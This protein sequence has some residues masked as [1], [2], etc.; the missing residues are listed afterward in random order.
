MR[1]ELL[2]KQPANTGL[3]SSYIPVIYPGKLLPS[4]MARS[5]FDDTMSDSTRFSE[6]QVV[7]TVLSVF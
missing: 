5:E 6:R 7:Y 3:A 4:I 1:G 2:A